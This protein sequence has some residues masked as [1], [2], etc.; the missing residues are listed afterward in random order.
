MFIGIFIVIYVYCS[1][2]VVTF[3]NI[4]LYNSDNVSTVVIVCI[5]VYL[6][7]FMYDDLYRFCYLIYIIFYPNLCAIYF[8]VNFHIIRSQ[9]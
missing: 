6:Y 5:F 3:V 2:S 7:R 8:N 9:S 1:S 4:S